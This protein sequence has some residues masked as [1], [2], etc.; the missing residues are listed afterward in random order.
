M[1]PIVTKIDGYPFLKKTFRKYE[2]FL[3]DIDELTR[4]L[5]PN[6]MEKSVRAK[7]VWGRPLFVGLVSLFL[8]SAS[9]GQ[10]LKLNPLLRH[11][12]K[13]E[14]SG[15]GGFG[16]A[17]VKADGDQTRVRLFVRV[18]PGVLKES[19]AARYPKAVFRSQIGDI[20]TAEVPLSRLDALAM[21]ADIVTAEAAVRH[22]PRLEVVRSTAIDSGNFLGI[23]DPAVTDF[24]TALGSGVVIGIIDTGIDWRHNDFILEGSTN[25]S[26]ILFLWDQTDTIGP[27]PGGSF[28][29]GT[30]WTQAD[31]NAEINAAPPGIVRSSDTSGHGTHVAGIAA[32]DGSATDGDIAAGTFVGIAP[33]ADLVIVKTSFLDADIVDAVQ[34]VIDTAASLG[35]RAVVNLSL[36]SHLGPHDGTLLMS[37]ALNTLAVS[38]PIIVSAGNERADQLHG[39]ASV[40]P[41]STVEFHIQ[42]TQT[43]EQIYTDFWV[44]NGDAYTVTVT[45]SPLGGDSVTAVAGLD[46]TSGTVNSATVDIYN[47]PG[48]HPSGDREIFIVI[49]DTN[50]IAPVDFYMTFTR[51]GNLATGRIDGWIATGDAKFTVR[52]SSDMTVGPPATAANVITVGSYCSKRSWTDTDSNPVTDSNCPASELGEMS[53]FSSLGP[54]RDGRNK[55]DIAA[56]GQFVASALSSSASIVNSLIAQ[57]DRHTFNNGTSIAAPVVTGMSAITLQRFPY[58]TGA[59]IKST[60]TA[61]ARSDSKVA[62]SGGLPNKFWGSGKVTH[63]AC[64]AAAISTPSAVTPT[65]LGHSSISITWGLSNFADSYNIYY[66]TNTSSLIANVSGPPFLFSG[67]TADTTYA[68]EVRGAGLCGEGPG[69]VSLSTPTGS[70]PPLSAAPNAPTGVAISPDTLQWSWNSVVFALSY[71]VHPATDIGG[72][73]LNTASAGFFHT[74]LDTNTAYGIV[75]AGRND[76]GVGPLS[77]SATVFTAAAAPTGLAASSIHVTSASLAWSLNGNPS[78]TIAALERSTDGVVYTQR[79]STAVIS[80]VEDGLTGCTSYFYRVRNF[81]GDS[82]ATAYSTPFS[83]KTQDSTPA[84]PGGLIAQSIGTRRIRLDWAGTNSGDA[85]EYLLYYDNAAGT[86]DYATTYTTVSASALSYTTD[87]LPILEGVYRFGIR[88]RNRCGVLEGNTDVTASAAALE[89]LSG[90]RAAIS[91]PESGRTI[92]GD[93]VTVSAGLL[94]G[95]LSQAREV[96]FEFKAASAAVWSPIPAA[97]VG[98]PN[99][100]TE[101]PFSIHW[102]VLALDATSYHVRAVATDIFS[103]TDD[104]SSVVTIVVDHTSPDVDETAQA[105]SRVRK[106]KRLYNAVANVVESGDEGTDLLTRVAIPAGALSESTVTLTLLNTPSTALNPPVDAAD[107]GLRAEITL[108]NGQ[109]SFSGGNTATLTFSYPD[110]NRDGV[111]D[112]TLYRGD[113]LKIYS[114]DLSAGAWRPDVVSTVDTDLRTV[115]GRTSHFSF[116]AVFA[117]MGIGL[118]SVRVYPNPYRPNSGKANDGVP[119]EGANLNSG[120]VFDRLPVDYTIRIYTLTGQEMRVLRTAGTGRRAQWDGRNSSGKDAASGVY[121]AVISSPGVDSVVKKVVVIR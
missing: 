38:T 109:T 114:Y 96:R 23:L 97:D 5:Y 83:F 18:R 94:Q 41:S 44:P 79:L 3:L 47:T 113:E 43:T 62:A 25:N 10:G 8:A 12:Q 6:T 100:D 32:G 68:V 99:P 71:D 65:S 56:P 76:S 17:G 20:L 28:T 57:D 98:H 46:V 13:S 81:N 49:R 48:T 105:G 74:N 35:K 106:R 112:G 52:V 51:T 59:E 111:M 117:P 16:P 95:T 37:S 30:Q 101:P 85:L 33:Q 119:F 26:R 70:L 84:A 11:V 116:F 103:S 104:F 77:P 27:A 108:S 55:P 34:Y 88:V 107:V 115:T 1:G 102:D 73:A 120:V 86:I 110:A 42:R 39:E 2:L 29:Y 90:V 93:R 121:F 31:I 82:I 91:T 4:G 22:S 72:A 118:D 63:F 80:A 21:D 75:V 53:P 40:P 7:S 69:G 54:T 50:S 14:V 87:V 92:D 24:G 58:L 9:Y 36:G 15:R 45:T 78:N 67:L 61:Q 66:A 60:L 19:L 89:A 64:L